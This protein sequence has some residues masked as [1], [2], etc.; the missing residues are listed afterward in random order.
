ME[1]INNLLDKEILLN[2]QSVI[3]KNLSIDLQVDYLIS[4]HFE[5]FISDEAQEWRLRNLYFITDKDGKKV[6]FQMNSVQE[7]FY[8]NYIKKGYKRIILLKSRQLG[9]TTFI[10]ILYLDRTIFK[11]NTESLQI[12]HKKADMTEIFNRKIVYAI[13]NLPKPIKDILTIS[14]AKAGRQQFSYPDGSVSGISVSL[15]GRGTTNHNLHISE[16]AKMVVL[17]GGKAEEVVKGA[18][19]T[20]SVSGS[21]IVESTAEGASGIFYDMFMSS[22]KRRTDITPVMTKAEFYPVFYSWRSDTDEIKKASFDGI[23][24]ADE[25]QE[26]E[27]NWLEYQQENELTDEELN[28]Y[29]LKWIGATKDVDTL[30]QEF[31]THPMEAFLSSGSP[32][33]NSRKAANF[34]DRCDDNYQR[35]DFINGEFIRDDRGDLY[36]YEDVKPGKNYVI[37]GDVA[38]G[39]LN[40]DYS[41]ACVLGYDKQIK[42]LYRGHIEPDD[43]K[44][45]VE[46]LGKRFNIAL[47]AIEFNKDGNWVNTALRNDNYPN[48]YVRTVVD[49]ITKETTRSYGWLTNK[50]NRDFMLGESKKHFNSTDMINCKP[51]LEEIL[52]FVRD[53]KGKPQAAVGSHDDIVISWSIA[54]AVLQGRVEKT[55]EVIKI[56]PMSVIF[57]IN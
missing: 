52:T 41:V 44:T 51:L 26:C 42:A 48:M 13:N 1:L 16:L 8:H 54:L 57:G 24:K 49:D 25:M 32:Y 21:C 36:I 29:Y 47:L 55:Q 22:W 17:G 11:P 5:T 12:A 20:V 2:G 28:F 37:G 7:D 31:P 23:I 15:S 10:S 56:S 40:G 34:L 30:H 43:Y 33:F 14:Q 53:K 46:A 27:I 45:L 35:Y 3:V 38:E 39:L 4:N 50:K 18:F 9:F 6:R 19:P